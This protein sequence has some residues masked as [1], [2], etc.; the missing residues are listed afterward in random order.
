[1]SLNEE[2]LDRADPLAEEGSGGLS[3]LSKP[4]DTSNTGRRSSGEGG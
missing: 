3:M 1:M 4:V 2:R